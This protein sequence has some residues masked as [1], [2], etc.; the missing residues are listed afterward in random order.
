MDLLKIF[1]I[2]LLKKHTGPV[3]RIILEKLK[4]MAWLTSLS[5]NFKLL[6]QWT[7]RVAEQL[8]VERDRNVMKAKTNIELLAQLLWE[9]RPPSYLPVYCEWIS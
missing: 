2:K 9:P 5:N 7:N 8:Q 1:L 4:E 3:I 6:L